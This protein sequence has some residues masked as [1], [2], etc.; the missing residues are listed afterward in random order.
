MQRSCAGLMAPTVYYA[1]VANGLPRSHL[2]SPLRVTTS[3]RSRAPFG[4]LP[5]QLFASCDLLGVM[6]A[7]CT[8]L[9][10]DLVLSATSLQHALRPGHQ[11]TPLHSHIARHLRSQWLDTQVPFL[12]FTTK[13]TPARQRLCDRQRI[14]AGIKHLQISGR[15]AIPGGI[16]RT[17]FRPEQLE[18]EVMV[19]VSTVQPCLRLAKILLMLQALRLS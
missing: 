5:L 15:V 3:Q 11:H 8:T 7:C 4:T 6:C 14:D 12:R 2:H 10:I 18:S 13:F 9:S 1:A 16:N 19:S 17:Y